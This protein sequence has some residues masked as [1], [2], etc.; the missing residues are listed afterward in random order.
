MPSSQPLLE[1]LRAGREGMRDEILAEVTLR[2]RFYRELPDDLRAALAERLLDFFFEMCAEYRAETTRAWAFEV[3]SRCKEQGATLADLLLVGRILRR[4]FSR[5]MIESAAVPA[6]AIVLLARLDAVSDD[7]VDVAVLL[8]QQNGRESDARA[9]MGEL[10]AGYEMLSLRTPAMMHA[11]DE[12]LRIIAVSDRWLEVLGYARDEVLGRPSTDFMTEPSQKAVREMGLPRLREEGK[13]FDLALQF[14]KKSRDV[15]DVLFSCIALRDDRGE[16]IRHAV[17]IQDIT[18]RMRAERAQLES[19]ERWRTL[20]ELAPLPLAVHRNG[21]LL[22]ANAAAARLFGG[23]VPEQ[24]VGTNVLDR[25]HPDDLPTVMER[26]RRG[27]L[28]DDVLPPLEER[29]LRLDGTLA[30]VEVSAQPIAFD[31]GRAMQVALIDVTA[32]KMAE[33]AERRNAAQA[34]VIRAQEDMLRALST[35]II[36]LGEGALV[37][38]LVGRVTG[39]RAE[40]ILE[41]L[42]EGVVAQQARVAIV[43]VTGVPA[44]DAAVADALVRTARA[45][46][47]LG[48]D[49]VLTGLGPAAARALVEIG[50]DLGGIVTRGTLRDGIVHALEQRPVRGSARSRSDLASGG[51]SAGLRLAERG[52]RG[53]PFGTKG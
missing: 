41:A 50:A 38:P 20:A 36:P 33:E 1:T 31:G 39:E 10:D 37:M 24:F 42:A 34:E 22:W 2:V 43:D 6:D 27:K 29:V 23:T 46:R 8:F 9:G 16:P 13:V 40:R 48:A 21:I 4:V 12:H 53:V 11:S 49:V 51:E 25:V 45:I 26:V 7:L 47:L 30:Y 28:S 14:V 18:E 15:L 52:T 5:R 17:V 19:E 35:P 3:F 32:R 44:M